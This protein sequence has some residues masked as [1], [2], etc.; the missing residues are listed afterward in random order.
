MTN[1]KPDIVFHPNFL[2]SNNA[3]KIFSHLL[4]TVVWDK[5]M[6]SRYTASFGVA[7]EYSDMNY[8]EQKML[9]SIE[10]MAFEVAKLIGFTPNNCLLNYYFDG[11]NKM[12]FHS[13][14]TSQ[15][16]K[17]TG[18][19]I[20]SLGEKRNMLFKHKQ[21]S[22]IKHSYLLENGALI[23]MSDEVQKEWLH[24]IPKSDTTLARISITFRKLKTV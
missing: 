20:I 11:K 21:F 18:V 13:D 2:N 9:E 24:S 19:A 12:G 10:R 8:L 6:A 22:D 4:E 14:N 16:V 3:S 1:L 23:Y 5:T 7:Y 17:G 15:L